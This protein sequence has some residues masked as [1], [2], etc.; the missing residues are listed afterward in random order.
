MIYPSFYAP[1]ARPFSASPSAQFARFSARGAA[2][3][4]SVCGKVL[5]KRTVGGAACDWLLDGRLVIW[6]VLLA[7]LGLVQGCKVTLQDI[8][9]WKGTVKGP[10]K[11]LAV[12]SSPK[13]EQTLRD[14]AAMALIEMERQDV[15][16]IA[17]LHEQ[18]KKMPE[19][20][21]T[22]V[23]DGI[24][25]ELVALLAGSG[26]EDGAPPLGA[27]SEDGAEED[28]EAMS[29]LE[30]RAKDAAFLV[31]PFASEPVRETLM[32]AVLDWYIV[33]FS[34]RSLTGNYSAE[35]VVQSFG[36]RAGESLVNVL[37]TRM[38]IVALLKLSELIRQVADEPTKDKAAAKLVAIEREAEEKPYLEWLK[39][40]LQE[41]LK[42]SGKEASAERV[43][44]AAELNRD[45]FIENGAIPAMKPFAGHP[46]VA[47]RLLAIA[48]KESSPEPRRIASLIALEGKATEAQVP[49]LLSIAL[50]EEN[51]VGV[52]DHA[53]DRVADTQSATA[54]P[55]LWPLVGSRS[56]AK[57]RW[58]AGELVLAIGGA[59][60]VPRLFNT[61][62]SGKGV[63]FDASELRGY[64][65]QI[66]Q[67]KGPP[68]AYL[69]NQLG[70]KAW[71]TR[72]LALLA[73]ERVG[74]ERDVQTLT[75]MQG[76][77]A[78]LEG[79]GWP[80]PPTVGTVAKE[81]VV[82]L[83]ERLE[84]SSKSS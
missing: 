19:A 11:L 31:T 77:K 15:E 12:M 61:L 4:Q 70:Q 75:M 28:G 36:A 48:S 37:S 62:P 17:E 59:E 41:Q 60:A 3:S 44:Q 78:A 65:K 81:S 82:F 10:G 7:S 76:D 51:P 26:E 50:N 16:G 49:T 54:L 55:K 72:T 46:M 68:M 2:C 1:S 45:N 24:A 53:F 14:R 29:N 40:R 34:G 30:I 25:P 80:D 64:A 6:L 63:R 13:Y 52:R 27:A 79:D 20:E 47:Q 32:R 9:T 66:G 57:V 58:R 74:E 69:R 23:V 83:K 33:D 38:S 22:R 43:Q 5:R 73:L 21:R 71:S 8:E 67:M 56:D 39:S 84:G 42:E 18:L 35:Q